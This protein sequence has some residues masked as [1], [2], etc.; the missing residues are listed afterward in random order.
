MPANHWD[1][2]ISNNTFTQGWQIDN[3]V[4]VGGQISADENAQAV[5]HDM[6]AQTRNVFDFIRN[7]LH[8]AGIDESCV[9]K[10]NTYFFVDGDWSEINETTKTVAN[11]Q[12]EYYPDPGPVSAA[13]RVTGFAFEDLLIEIEAIA[14]TES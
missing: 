7:T 9:V 10:I 11:I 8:E 3:F 14:V 6:A 12:K 1:W 4:F 13:V 2:S 5:G